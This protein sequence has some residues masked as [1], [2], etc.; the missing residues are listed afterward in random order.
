MRANTSE[1]LEDRLN[2]ILAEEYSTTQLVAWLN[3]SGSSVNSVEIIIDR[4]ES[5]EITVD[6]AIELLDTYLD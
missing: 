2:W 1:A 5:G 3:V 4:L 6:E